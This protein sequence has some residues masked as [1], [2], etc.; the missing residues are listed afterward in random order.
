MPTN[1]KQDFLETIRQDKDFIICAACG[2]PMTLKNKGT[3]RVVLSVNARK[4]TNDLLRAY[5]SLL[6]NN[7]D[8]LRSHNLYGLRRIELGFPFPKTSN[9]DNRG[10]YNTSISHT[11]KQY[12]Q[13]LDLLRISEN[14]W[15]LPTLRELQVDNLDEE[16]TDD[17]VA[18]NRKII[19]VILG[20]FEPHKI[21]GPITDLI[22]WQPD[23]RDWIN[24]VRLGDSSSDSV[25][26]IATSLAPGI[27]EA[28]AADGRGSLAQT[29]KSLRVLDV[30][31]K[32][33]KHYYEYLLYIFRLMDKDKQSK[34][35]EEEA[36]NKERIKDR[37][38]HALYVLALLLGHTH[39]DIQDDG[40]RPLPFLE[41]KLAYDLPRMVFLPEGL[42]SDL[43]RAEVIVTNPGYNFSEEYRKHITQGNATSPPTNTGNL[44]LEKLEENLRAITGSHGYLQDNFRGFVDFICNGRPGSVP[45]IDDTPETPTGPSGTQAPSNQPSDLSGAS[46]KTPEETSIDEKQTRSYCGW[47]PKEEPTYPVLLVGSPATTKSS[48]MLSGLTVFTQ[49][50]SSLGFSVR[51]NSA[52]D[53]HMLDAYTRQYYA[54]KMPKPTETNSRYSVQV[55][56]VKTDDPDYRVNFVFTDVP[57]EM[58]K[59]SLSRQDTHPVVMNLAKYAEI[60]V[61]F[62]DIATEPAI[63]KRVFYGQASNNW[64]NLIEHVQKIQ[65]E[66]RGDTNQIALLNKL[67]EDLRDMRGTQGV[68]DNV[69]MICVIP[70][71]DLY[72][73]SENQFR[74]LNPFYD[75]LREKKV[76]DVSQLGEDQD[77]TNYDNLR[78]EGAA[79]YQIEGE[80]SM[81]AQGAQA[82]ITKQSQV[83]SMISNLAKTNLVNI[84]DMLNE[85]NASESDKQVLVDMVKNSLFSQLESTFK[86]VY[87]LPVSAQGKHAIP[88]RGQQAVAL[89][90]PPSQKLAEYVF[91]IPAILALREEEKRRSMSQTNVSEIGA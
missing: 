83:V 81:N 51:S 1:T 24:D 46:V 57:G 76:V 48:V 62:F 69:S 49:A 72:T 89:R 56:I 38:I 18:T 42:L 23:I 4:V 28:K 31:E 75:T 20:G 73:G 3:F 80:G 11:T 50:A 30:V 5:R 35:F 91:I 6:Q 21:I 26:N 12:L 52:D 66:G 74:F 79:V 39:N 61:F 78:S 14:L 40:S 60:I 58:L 77:P 53:N 22:L 27:A 55:T 86:E 17:K 7:E 47:Y 13:G 68:R 9:V 59:R 16:P 37:A 19:N 25:P 85:T 34:I 8:D 54:G 2:N 84:G 33:A 15:Q 36:F 44:S 45:E 32:S 71:A 41:G 88:D 90:K 64:R 29:H 65:T 82:L 67:L 43:F 87:F 10:I 63:F 70:K